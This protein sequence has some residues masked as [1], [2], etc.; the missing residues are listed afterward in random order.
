MKRNP[1]FDKY[2]VNKSIY[3]FRMEGKKQ[4]EGQSPP[5]MQS[6]DNATVV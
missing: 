5:L 6:E 4:Y 3:S 2:I 1:D